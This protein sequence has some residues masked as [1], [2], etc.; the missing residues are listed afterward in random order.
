MQHLQKTC[1]KINVHINSIGGSVLEGYSIVSAILNSPV[2]VH[3]HIDG[4]AA[5]IA[6]VIAV[7]GEHVHVK[8]YGTW[9][10]HDVAGGEDAKLQNL[11][12]D[13]LVTILT[14]RTKKTPEDI[15][16]MLSKET[17]ISN[18]RQADFSLEQGVEM[19]FFTSIEKTGKKV[20]IKKTDSLLNMAVLYNSLITPEMNEA[21]KLL[22]LSNEASEDTVVSEIKKRD[23][24]IVTLKQRITDIEKKEADAAIA[25]KT[26]LTNKATTLANSLVTDGKLKAEEVP[27]TISALVNNWDFT[28]GLLGKLTNVKTAAKIFDLK[29]VAG[30]DRSAWDYKTWCEKDSKGLLELQN[31]APEAFKQLIAKLPSKLSESYTGL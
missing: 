27:A 18:S 26:E 4:M 25:A 15:N 24:E 12:K 22:G 17:W 7:A 21:K 11:A 1:N 16:A 5:S 19:G 8:D 2:P 14:N 30:E 23:N 6:G 31:T 29:N 10:G 28:A 20:N 13:T 9:M 3:T